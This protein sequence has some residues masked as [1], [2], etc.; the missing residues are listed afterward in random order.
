MQWLV[1]IAKSVQLAPNPGL[2]KTIMGGGDTALATLA[3]VLIFGSKR[4]RSA[5]L[6][7]LAMSVVGSYLCTV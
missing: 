3:G 7:G 6:V 4:L 2:S 5:N 1:W